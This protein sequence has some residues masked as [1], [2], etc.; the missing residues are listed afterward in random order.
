MLFVSHV[1]SQAGTF[2]KKYIIINVRGSAAPSMRIIA[3]I[4]SVINTLHNNPRS[5][6]LKY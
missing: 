1:K 4:A 5:E 2:T 3:Y 6:K